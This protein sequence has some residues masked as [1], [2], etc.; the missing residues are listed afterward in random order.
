MA[1]RFYLPSSGSAPITIPY[2]SV[3]LHTADA[4]R[5]QLSLTKDDSA[6]VE[7]TNDP[8]TGA[9]R[10]QRL[11]A[12]YIWKLEYATRF[13][14]NVRVSLA[15][16]ET[17][18]LVAAALQ[19]SFRV[20]N[21]DGS[22]VTGGTTGAGLTGDTSLPPDEFPA[23]GSR[24]ASR[25]RSSLRSYVASNSFVAPAGSYIVV[26]LGV[27]QGDVSATAN[28]FG[29]ITLGAPAGVTDH[30]FLTANAD[31][32]NSANF[33]P[34]IEFEYS[35]VP[36]DA[37]YNVRKVTSASDSLRIAWNPPPGGYATP[38]AYQYRV[39][40]GNPVELNNVTSAYITGLAA[41]SDYTVQ[42]RSMSN[43][44]PSPWSSVVTLATD[45]FSAEA[46]TNRLS[47]NAPETRYF[48]GGL[49]RG[50][51]YPKKLES[52][53][54]ILSTNLLTN[55]SFEAGET[56][57]NDYVKSSAGTVA[58]NVVASSQADDGA[59]YL[60]ITASALFNGKG[61]RV[62][63]RANP[64]A[65]AE[66]TVFTIGANF[67]GTLPS[68]YRFMIGAEYYR[69]NGTL[70]QI[71]DGAVYSLGGSYSHV[72]TA[73][74]GTV[75]MSPIFVVIGTSVANVS[76]S[77][78]DFRLDSTWV[79]WGVGGGFFS[80]D[81]PMTAQYTHQWAGT[82]HASVSYRRE[83]LANA[84][85]WNGLIS[86]EEESS[87]GAASYY[88]DGRPFL[89]LP[90]PREYKATLEAYTYPDA[91]SEI[92]G[93]AE[94]ADGMYLDSQMGTAF[95]LCYRTRV[96]NATEGVD[97]GYKIHLVYNATVTPGALSYQTLSDSI[98]P[99]TFSWDI[100]AVPV[101]VEGFRPTAH[102]I[103]DTRHMDAKRIAA[104]EALIYGDEHSVPLMPSPQVIFDL[105]SFG[106]AIIVTDNGDGTFD[107]TGTYDNVYM[108]G[109]GVFRVDNVNGQDNGDGTFTI[110]STNV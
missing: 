84:V 27:R 42:V 93:V 31:A 14:G 38:D 36:P 97:H 71:D 59:S 89:H 109:D 48:D 6:L 73:P 30:P 1:T 63:V 103:I 50:V 80:G 64:V 86:V 2:H 53:G 55:P 108:I 25:T 18:D 43:G 95:D 66:T 68:D 44:L 99:T 28:K 13:Y 37:P 23:G 33:V 100:Q 76:P 8:G 57:W 105:L 82:P 45:P 49:D 60:S 107:V 10:G 47:W 52:I 81:S 91:F 110:S 3:W 24:T 21:P 34:W 40:G 51:L 29:T 5:R 77:P 75:T 35:P 19:W 72:F 96:G 92:M 32:T 26:E 74:A 9:N 12:Q 67:N 94:V 56:G 98:N 46:G 85:P 20:V 22:L 102:I 65:M 78:I 88:I 11:H 61:N 83:R 39:N 104:V 54:A 4:V 106:D 16:R 101:Q 69:S 7:L 15:G 79:E 17:D 41:G 87:E 58:T 62:G 70:I 90:R